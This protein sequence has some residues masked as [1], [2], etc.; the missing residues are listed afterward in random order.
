[1]EKTDTTQESRQYLTFRLA[2]ETYGI[3]VHKVREILDFP[4]LTKVPRAPEFMLG[5]INLRGHVVPVVDLRKRFQLAAGEQTKE[6]CIIVLEI[7]LAGEL[8]TIG[9]VGD[10]VE[11]VIDLVQSQIEPPP[12]LGAQLNTEFI[13]GMGTQ[14]E[15]FIL[16]LDIDKIFTTEELGDVSS[17]AEAS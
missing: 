2:D 5:V 10:S 3:E 9:I 12:K 6:S 4:V 11:E 16:L 14:G 1:M 17:M 15:E 7:D 8:L 13:L